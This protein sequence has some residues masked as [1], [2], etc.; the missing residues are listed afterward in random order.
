V[1][2]GRAFY[3]D[4]PE[5]DQVWPT[6][7]FDLLPAGIRGLIFVALIAAIMSTLDSVLNGA[8]SLVVNDFI[9]TQKKWKF[10]DKQLLLIGRGIIA[11]FML[12]AALWA[13]QILRFEGM[14][15]YFQSFLGHI[16]TPVVVVFLSGLFWPRGTRQAAFYTLLI[17][18]PIGLIL[19]LTNEIFELYQFQF[20]YAT[21]LMLLFSALLF[22]TISLVTEA[23]EREKLKKIMWSRYYWQEESTE[24]KKK[25]LWKN[26][27]IHAS[28]LMLITFS[29]IWIFR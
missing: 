24:L 14:V 25:P 29:M 9:K 3:P 8:A 13:P 19:F 15:E 16:T 18:T 17:A 28:M 6:L 10:T 1:V 22:I 4:L 7:V 27:R 26:Y 5:P 11:V 2:R 20:L 23:P 12:L 21:G